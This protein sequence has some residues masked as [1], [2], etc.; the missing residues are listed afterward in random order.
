MKAT[1]SD[2]LRHRQLTLWDYLEK[3]TQEEES[4]RGVCVSPR[5]AETDTTD[6]SK[7]EGGLLEEILSPK[8]MNRTYKQVKRNKGAGGIDRMTVDELRRWIREN[9]DE[10]LESLGNGNYRPQPVR[11]VEIPKEN[12]KTRRLGIRT[13]VDRMI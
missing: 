2:E 1:K 13:V 10:M 11:R 4:Y 8:N 9:R 3:D 6:T 5:M 7:Q 12:G